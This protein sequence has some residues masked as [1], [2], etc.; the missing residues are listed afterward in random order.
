MV[1][2]AISLSGLPKLLVADRGLMFESFEL[3]VLPSLVVISIIKHPECTMQTAQVERNVRTVLNIIL[4][5]MV[6]T[7][8]TT[9]VYPWH[10][11]AEDNTSLSTETP[12]GHW[13]HATWRRYSDVRK[14]CKLARAVQNKSSSSFEKKTDQT[15]FSCQPT[16]A[17][18]T[19]ILWLNI[20]SSQET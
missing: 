3:S 14:P 8:M 5:G 12:S 19:R 6:S 9:S 13:C 4:C 1:T 11:Q 2:N 16:A 7:T 17:H 20:L 10:Y 15:S 18:T